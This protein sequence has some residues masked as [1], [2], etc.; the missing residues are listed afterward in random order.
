MG[1]E[2]RARVDELTGEGRS[3]GDAI[4]IATWEHGH[5]DD[6]NPWWDDNDPDEEYPR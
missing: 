5:A 3:S 6:P 2:L 1:P 4:G